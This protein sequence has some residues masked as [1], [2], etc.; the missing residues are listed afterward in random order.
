MQLL[1]G[2]LHHVSTMM[3]LH[4]PDGRLLLFTLRD[5]FGSYL[6]FTENSGFEASVQPH[7]VPF[8]NTSRSWRRPVCAPLLRLSAMPLALP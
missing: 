3:Q 4:R 6:V 5:S 8:T 7:D 2:A 1:S